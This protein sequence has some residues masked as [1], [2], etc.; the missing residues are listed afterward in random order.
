[1]QTR[2]FLQNMPLPVAAFIKNGKIRTPGDRHVSVRHA[3]SI[4][5]G[6]HCQAAVHF[7][8]FDLSGDIHRI[9]DSC[10][11]SVSLYVWWCAVFV[12]STAQCGAA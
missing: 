6:Q 3:F 11:S 2:A 1:M 10:I 12:L 8:M 9:A 4:L 5:Y 7:D